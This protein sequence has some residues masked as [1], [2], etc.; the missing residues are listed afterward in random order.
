MKPRI[1]ESPIQ[2]CGERSWVCSS[3]LCPCR[4]ALSGVASADINPGCWAGVLEVG[5][6]DVAR[7]SV[8]RVSPAGMTGPGI[9]LKMLSAPSALFQYRITGCAGS[10]ARTSSP[11]LCHRTSSGAVGIC[12]R[13]C[14]CVAELALY[15]VST[16]S[17]MMTINDVP[18]KT[19]MP[20]VDIRRSRD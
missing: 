13:W 11:L 4:A 7:G 6:C 2:A 3:G 18:T 1:R 14:V 17:G 19:P 16:P 20:I 15:S 5:L 12:L 9:S 10:A 8:L